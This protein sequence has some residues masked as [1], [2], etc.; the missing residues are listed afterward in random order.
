MIDSLSRFLLLEDENDNAAITE[1][2]DRFMSAVVRP[3][4]V[5]SLTIHHDRKSGGEH[6]RGMRGVLT[7]DRFHSVTVGHRAF[8]PR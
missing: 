2:W 5:C 6:G 1:A 8:T 4:N 7:T 3:T